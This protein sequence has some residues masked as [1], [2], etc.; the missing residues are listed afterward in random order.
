MSQIKEFTVSSARPLPVLLL[1][2][3]SGSMAANGKID[4]LNDAV[5]EMI[6]TFA[7][8]DTA[9][10]EIQVGVVTFGHG[11]ARLH[12]P[13]LA[14]GQTA[15][16]R[17]T[18]AGQTPLGAAL[19]LVREIVEDRDKLPSRA[20]RPTLILVSDGH[21]T[22]AWQEPLA[23]LLASERGAKAARFAMAIGEDAD[24]SMLGAFLAKPD[25]RVFKAQEARQ[26]KQFFRWATMTVAMRSRSVNPNEI[27][28]PEL[29]DLDDFAF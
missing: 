10:A 6:S 21:P 27:A 8:E 18:A 28:A 7:E 1:A 17:M 3:V 16:E 11:G 23:R 5:A 4:T 25:A 20:Y 22:D 15:W 9:R 2:D 19:D 24:T 13:L 26:I 14:A 12:Q 29:T